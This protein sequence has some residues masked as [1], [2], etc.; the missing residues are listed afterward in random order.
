MG[1]SVTFL[2][3]SF[4]VAYIIYITQRKRKN[5]TMNKLPNIFTAALITFSLNTFAGNCPALSGE[6]TIGSSQNADFSSIQQASDALTCGGVSSPVIFHIE[7]GIYNEKVTLSNIPGASAL[8]TIVFDSKSGERTDVIVANKTSDA[9]IVLNGTSYVSFENITVDHK[10][11]TYGNC[12]R[13]EGKTNHLAFKSVIFDGVET[14]AKGTASAVV[15]M[16]ATA[17]K[18]DVS[19][20]DCEINNGSIGLSKSGVS[21]EDMDTKTSIS[22]NLFF[23][24]TEAGISMGFEDAPEI[25]N[26]VVSS[27]GNNTAYTAIA[28]NSAANQIIVTKNVI[29]APNGSTGL[30]LTNCNA[31]P[32]NLGQIVNN[33]IVAGNSGISINGSTDNQILNFNRVKL[34]INGGGKTY[35]ANSGT[36]NNINMMNNIFFDMTTGAY[37]IIGNSYKDFFNQLPSQSN[38]DM[39]ASA[40]GIMVEKVSPIK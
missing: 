5:E 13:A 7:N 14:D 20:H 18:N 2:D 32:T 40:N 38:P 6:F 29:N 23:N 31:Q 4:C 25:A 39:Q 27:V 33:S 22:G 30:A 37:T 12:V 26:N 34:S 9:T 3:K 21:A 36:G 24:Q 16:T 8:N 15:Y 19:M 1:F 28:L 17:A 10:A 11:A 35:Y